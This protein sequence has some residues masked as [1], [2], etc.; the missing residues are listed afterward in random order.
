MWVTDHA[1]LRVRMPRL[2][3]ARSSLKDGPTF[4]GDLRAQNVD[5]ANTVSRNAISAGSVAPRE[6]FRL[7][8]DLASTMASACHDRSYE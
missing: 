4:F 3:F 5:L 2:W 1:T 6:E 8:S 7:A